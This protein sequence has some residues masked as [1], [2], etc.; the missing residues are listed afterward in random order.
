MQ[1]LFDFKIKSSF[2]YD[3]KIINYKN[4]LESRNIN[5]LNSPAYS[6]FFIDF[7]YIYISIWNNR[8]F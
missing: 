1:T 6:L 4:L 3:Y 5:S 2:N 8:K 7:L